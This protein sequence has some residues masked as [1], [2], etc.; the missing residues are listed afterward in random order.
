MFLVSLGCSVFLFLLL[1]SIVIPCKNT[2]LILGVGCNCRFLTWD[3]LSTRDPDYLG[4][5]G[6][7]TAPMVAYYLPVLLERGSSE[8]FWWKSRRLWRRFW[9]FKRRKKSRLQKAKALDIWKLEFWL[10]LKAVLT[11]V[12]LLPGVHHITVRSLFWNPNEHL[13]WVIFFV[14][15][16]VST[17]P[18]KFGF[19]L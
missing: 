6:L 3:L 18:L 17:T 2:V 8:P 5:G 12:R 10:F 1:L 11:F 19:C 9:R 16:L 7:W 15:F 14:P 4:T 13:S